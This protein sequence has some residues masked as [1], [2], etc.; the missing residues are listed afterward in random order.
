MQTCSAC[1]SQFTITPEEIK[2]IDK[3]SPI[4]EGKKFPIPAPAICPD[5]RLRTRTAHRNEQYMYMNK[6]ANTGESLLSLYSPDTDWGKKYKIVTDSEWWSDKWD[7][8][9]FGRD[10]DF[11]RP[12]F[13][14]FAELCRD[15]PH[16]N[17]IQVG[18][19][20]SPFTTGTGYCKNC[21]LINCSENSQ[22]CY[23]GKLVQGCTDAMDC[24]YA[25]DSELLY[26]CFY[27]TKCYDC[28]YV[29]YSQNSSECWFSENLKGCSNCFLCTNLS[30]KRYYF[31][32]QPLEKGQY[33]A[34]MKEFLGSAQNVEKAKA[35][36][37]DMRKKRIHKYAT[38][39]NSENSTGDFLTGC[40]NC[41]DCYDVN[42]SEDSKYVTVGVNVK[43]NFDCSNMYLKPE[44]SYQV[45]GTIGTYNVIFSLYIFNSQDVM[46]SEFCY[47]SKNLFGC[48]GLRKKQYCIFNKQYTKEEYEKLVPKIIEHMQKTTLRNGGSLTGSSACEWGQYFPV[49]YSPFGYNETVA[50]EYLPL[51]KEQ[52]IAKGYHWKDPDNREYKPQ[53]YS[54]P[55]DIKDVKDEITNQVLACKNVLNDTSGDAL[56]ATEPAK[57]CGRNYK[58]IPQELRR[59]RNL[60]LPVP[61]KCPDCRHMDRMKLRNARKLYDRTCAKC[62]ATI[63]T[64]FAPDRSRSG[65]KIVYCEKCY[66]QAVY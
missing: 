58:I 12:F 41:T 60:N 26:E 53:T 45:L 57:L 17:L 54:V 63:K 5:C 66:L 14:Q 50:Q 46:Y 61:T 36:L 42:D 18:N 9:D 35:I 30:N 37:D 34:K 33:E 6:S 49:K 64:T 51:T 56:N 62:N 59:L 13:E 27:V 24:S 16:V 38:I 19:E 39:I 52:A 8:T 55:A 10:F 31:M 29:Y 1:Q 47:N 3:I 15:I 48:S 28:K 40:K 44:L 23:Y 21:Y 4:F 43:D 7:G 22:D 32:N 25:Y 11:N 65:G 2:F 20:N